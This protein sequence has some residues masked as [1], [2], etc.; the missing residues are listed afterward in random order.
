MQIFR[1]IAA[2]LALIASPVLVAPAI[3]ADYTIDNSHSSVLFKTDY[4]GVAPFW[5]R[6]NKVEGQFS[7]DAK[8]PTA[9]TLAVTIDANSIFTADKKRDDHLKSPDFFNAKQFP[10]ITLKSVAVKAG[11]RAD[12][13]VVD[14]DLT[15]R[16][17]TRRVTIALAKTGEGKDPWGGVRVG[18][19]GELEI[20]RTEFGITYMPDGIG[21]KVAILFAVQGVKK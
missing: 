4:L 10:A 14:A 11:P 5:G 9:S 17:V 13:Y 12:S 8:S 15:V 3:A 7:Y 19:E 20:D 1:S 18:F 16:G 6:F 21:K 2:A